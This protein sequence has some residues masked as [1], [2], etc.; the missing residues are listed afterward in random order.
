MSSIFLKVLSMSLTASYVAV[1][2]IIARFFLKKA[3]KIF[4]YALWA[5][6]LFRLLCPFSLES[7]VSLIPSNVGNIPE[8]IVYSENPSID[9]GVSAIDNAVNTAISNSI[10]L[11]NPADSVNPIDVIVEISSL[12]WIVGVMILLIY[13]LV[14]YI[15]LKNKLAVATLVNDNIFETDQIRTPFVMGII[16]PKIFIPVNIP[17]DEYNY[18]LKHEQTHIKRYDYLIKPFFFI[19]LTIHW[20]NPLMWLSYFLM[21]KDMEMSCDESV[22]KNT[23]EDIRGKYSNSLLSLSV[24]QSGL[25]VP[26]AF[27]ESNVKSRIKN[28]L[29]YKKTPFWI[30][31]AVV[32]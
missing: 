30:L 23:H 21:A 16:K 28:I 25:L 15:K 13:G 2:V 10:P 4:S 29:N 22:M 24:K 9:T 11:V 12:I 14:S 7:S 17:N 18:I 8:N 32:I 20:F 19:A 1:A 31:V 5:V 26:L 6:V 27:G 3:P